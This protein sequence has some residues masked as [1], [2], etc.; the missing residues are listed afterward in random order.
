TSEAIQGAKDIIAEHISDNAEYRKWI[1]EETFKK[2]VFR[3]PLKD[4][5][6]EKDQKGVYEMYYEYEEPVS[7]IV[8]HRILAMNR[9]EKDEVIRISIVPPIDLII[10][11]LKRKVCKSENTTAMIYIVEAIEDG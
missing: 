11:Y 4:K 1:R 6:K 5:G 10:S 9:G 8:P 7:R 3:T 2:S